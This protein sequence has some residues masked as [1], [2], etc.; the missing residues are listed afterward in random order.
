MRYIRLFEDFQSNKF[1]NVKSNLDNKEYLDAVTLCTEELHKSLPQV[2]Y[3][4]IFKDIRD[5]GNPKVSLLALDDTNYPLGAAI[6]YESEISKDIEKFKQHDPSFRIEYYQ[7]INKFDNL[8]G[9][10]LEAISVK[11]EFRNNKIASKLLDAMN[12]TS[13]DYIFLKQDRSL[14]ENIDYTKKG[15]DL[16][17]TMFLRNEKSLCDVYA[18]I[19]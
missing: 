12:N 15:Y 17:Y 10:E 8:K 16:I 4:Y 11:S 5:K 9:I 18:K 3:N 6:C 14:K 1:F 7:D 19:N 13:Y 2:P